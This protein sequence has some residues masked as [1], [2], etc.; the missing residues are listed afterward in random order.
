MCEMRFSI[1]I[2]SDQPCLIVRSGS[3]GEV[4]LRIPFKNTKEIDRLNVMLDIAKQQLEDGQ[5]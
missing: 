3:L 2:G 5:K 4:V 1:E